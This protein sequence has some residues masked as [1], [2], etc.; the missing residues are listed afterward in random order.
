MKKI[1]AFVCMATAALAGFAQNEQ[2]EINTSDDKFSMSIAG[3]KID[4]ESDGDRHDVDT[5]FN[6][7]SNGKSDKSFTVTRKRAA[8]VNFDL[9]GPFYFGWNSLVGSNYYGD[10]AGQGDFLRHSSAFS[11]SMGF[12]RVSTSLN[13]CGSLRFTVGARWTLT[14]YKYMNHMILADNPLGN[15]MP[16]FN[17]ER[18][19]SKLRTSYVGFPVGI[20]YYKDGFRLRATISAEWLTNSYA[21]FI[22]EDDKF[23]ISGVNNFRSAV[24]LIIGYRGIGGYVSYCITPIFNEGCGNDAHALTAGFLIFM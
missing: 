2:V 21:R 12:C 8:H 11:F 9:I 23:P 20:S 10:W 13:Y 1:I 24:E 6:V 17:S 22:D 18:P 19:A 14:T 15:P 16:V 5:I 4:F 7:S 3:F